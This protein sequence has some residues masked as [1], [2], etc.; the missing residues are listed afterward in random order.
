MP[1]SKNPF[2][3]SDYLKGSTATASIPTTPEAVPP[4]VQ[5]K[6]AAGTVA[7]ESPG[8]GGSVSSGEYGLEQKS[9][10]TGK[11]RRIVVRGKV[12]RE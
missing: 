5:P 2:G 8:K 4:V 9:Y 11:P 6:S 7:S 12:S 3:K 1:S 10:G